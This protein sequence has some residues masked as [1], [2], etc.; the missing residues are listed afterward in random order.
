MGRYAKGLPKTSGQQMISETDAA[1][2]EQRPLTKE[3]QE[4]LAYL[5]GVSLVMR[6]SA[7]DLADPAK[8]AAVLGVDVGVGDQTA[9]HLKVADRIIAMRQVLAGESLRDAIVQLLQETYQ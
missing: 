5:P 1:V 6:P 9:V 7:K 8:V 3:E 2:F 4:Q